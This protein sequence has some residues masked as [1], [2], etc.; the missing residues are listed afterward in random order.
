MRTE[1]KRLERDTIEKFADKH[2]LVMEVR[3]LDVKTFGGEPWAASFKNA[4]TKDGC[5]LAYESGRGYSPEEA[6]TDYAKIISRKLL[7]LNAY[8]KEKRREILVPILDEG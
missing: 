8:D 3:E 1:Y 2:G 7:V 6:I 5:I 4:E